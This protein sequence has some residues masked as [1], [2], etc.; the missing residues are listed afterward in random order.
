M[1]EAQEALSYIA[2]VA[3][4]A[5]EKEREQRRE[6]GVPEGAKRTEVLLLYLTMIANTARKALPETEQAELPAPVV[7]PELVEGLANEIRDAADQLQTK[8][9]AFH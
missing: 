7:D 4:R 3:I 9:G 8:R 5:I 2:R 1:N 6:V